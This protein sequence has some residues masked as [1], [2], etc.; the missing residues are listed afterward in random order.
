MARI[1]YI[2]LCHKDPE[3]V[4]AQARR[5]TA[6]GDAMA[7][8]F[9]ANAPQ[10]AFDTIARQLADNPAVT[11]VR[12]RER[13]GWGSW[14]LVQAT[15]NAMEAALAAFPDA[16][17]FYMLSGDCMAIKS[18]EYA[19]AFL[20]AEDVDYIESFDFFHSDWIKTGIKEDRLVY[21]HYFNERRNKRLFYASMAVQKCRNASACAAASP[22]TSR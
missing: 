14:S 7:I 17:H 19:H 4:V 10:A 9:D 18:A 12:R 2:L 16:S 1:A 13:C 8:H 3:G 22:P 15:L 20:D 5:L 21:R 6:A 11:L